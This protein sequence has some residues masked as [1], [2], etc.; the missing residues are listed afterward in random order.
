MP[1]QHVVRPVT[2]YV[3]ACHHGGNPIHATLARSPR[4]GGVPPLG[5]TRQLLRSRGADARSVRRAVA[6]ALAG[7][8]HLRASAG[9]PALPP[10]LVAAF[11]AELTPLIQR[12]ERL[13][14]RVS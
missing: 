4:P 10:A 1:D 3:Y 11:R 13:E 2:T 6:A 8:A 9:A 7:Y 14:S 5:R 12:I